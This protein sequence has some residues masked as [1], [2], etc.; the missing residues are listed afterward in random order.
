MFRSAD[1]LRGC[2]TQDLMLLTPS[3]PIICIMSGVRCCSDVSWKKSKCDTLLVQHGCKDVS[4]VLSVARQ[5]RAGS[6]STV[7]ERRSVI[8][9]GQDGR[10]RPRLGLR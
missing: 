1:G 2:S 6:L 7:L 10:N 3:D 5:L 8:G 9:L 4:H